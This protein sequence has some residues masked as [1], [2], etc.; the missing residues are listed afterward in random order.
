MIKDIDKNTQLHLHNEAQFLC[1][2]LDPEQEHTEHGTYEQQIY[3]INVFKV[4]EIIYYNGDLT[5]TA[6]E[7]DG[8]VLGF[9]TVRG[10][11]IP[12]I[13]M[14]RWLHHTPQDPHRNLKPFSIESDKSL[15]VICNF[16]NQDVGLKI[17]GVKHIIHRSWNE[18]E[19]GNEFGFDGN[20]KV[21]ATTKY[22]DGSVIQ[23]LDVEKMI[24]DAVPGLGNS[25]EFELQS[26][27]KIKTDKVVLMAEDSKSA[28]KA[29]ESV[30]EK[31]EVKYVSFGNGRALL[32]YLDNDTAI[33]RVG[34]VIT[35]LEMPMVSGFEVLRQI[36]N[37]PKL[38]HIPVIVNSSM[39][40][41]S[42]LEMANSLQASG[43]I[44]KSNPEEVSYHLR[45]LLAE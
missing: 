7:N 21:V 40:N 23:I 11:S 39:S 2:T 37:N 34:A 42:N 19:M 30:L 35:D 31:L 15:V 12:L 33:P 3:A 27:G 43:F 6:G 45:K 32:D 16:S 17:L 8:L 20:R 29:L 14:R 41:D 10:E 9:L 4:R 44:T 13:D 5:E 18:V 26:I 22:D 1:F 25:L 38:K 28:S 24:V 36:K